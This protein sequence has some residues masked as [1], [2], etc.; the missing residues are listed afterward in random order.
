MFCRHAPVPLHA[1]RDWEFIIARLFSLAL[2]VSG[3]NLRLN[4]RKMAQ[5]AQP[6]PKGE[7]MKPSTLT[8]I[9]ATTLV[10]IVAAPAQSLAQDSSTAPEA[11]SKHV[12]YTITDLGPVGAPP[13]LPYFIANS[14]LI[15][16]AAAS[17]DGALHAVL[18]LNQLK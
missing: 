2:I 1:W 16:G 18:W 4:S 12:R 5:A 3:H 9:T 6:K 8:R 11:N 15:A 17:S 13:A 7:N 14:G 10:A